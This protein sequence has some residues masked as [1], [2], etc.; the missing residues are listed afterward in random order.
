MRPVIL[1]MVS[2]SKLFGPA[3]RVNHRIICMRKLCDTAVLCFSNEFHSADVI[4]DLQESN[5][6]EL[7]DILKFIP[8][9]N[10]KNFI[11][12]SITSNSNQS[13]IGPL[14]TLLSSA[15]FEA[16]IGLR[17]AQKRVYK[18]SDHFFKDSLMPLLQFAHKIEILDG[19]LLDDVGRCHLNGETP[20][21]LNEIINVF[22]GLI[23]F[24]SL[25]PKDNRSW[26]SREVEEKAV[27]WFESAVKSAGRE[28]D[29]I[30]LRT[31]EYKNKDGVTFP[32]DRQIRI[33]YKALSGETQAWSI[34][35]G[36]GLSTFSNL[37]TTEVPLVVEIS[38]KDAKNRMAP[39]KALRDKSF[40][41][42]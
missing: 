11:D 13:E 3:D 21:L 7:I 9:V 1:S 20:W 17:S 15:D 27:S 24:Y 33:I 35:L 5:N 31:K 12:L 16:K 38:N 42:L 6:P 29:T 28:K 23:D 14:T 39:M 40:Y 10:P 36:K 34:G 22:D 26:M 18:N 30:S 41:T 8:K 4:T 32:H 25:P 19:Y 37:V 2:P